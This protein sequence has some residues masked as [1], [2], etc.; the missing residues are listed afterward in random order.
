[1][2]SYPIR[3]FFLFLHFFQSLRSKVDLS[4]LVLRAFAYIMLGLVKIHSTSL[5]MKSKV[6]LT[7][8]L[9]ALWFVGYEYA[10]FF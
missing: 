1:M 8:W 10:F 4:I 5:Q 3:V 2:H 6:Y 7:I 9:L